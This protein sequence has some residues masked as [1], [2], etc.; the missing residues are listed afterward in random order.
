MNN[1]MYFD[2]DNLFRAVGRLFFFFFFFNRG[3]QRVK[4]QG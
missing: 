3:A 2:E 4:G 1:L